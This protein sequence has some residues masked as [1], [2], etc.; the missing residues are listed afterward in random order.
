[1]S[2]SAPTSALGAARL[3]LRLRVRRLLN[4]VTSSFQRLRR[5]PITGKRT[6]TPAKSKLGWFVGSLVA[7]SMVFSLTNLARQAMANIKE[8]L[9]VLDASGLSRN[10]GMR[11]QTARDCF[12]VTEHEFGV[13][14]GVGDGGVAREQPKCAVLRGTGCAADELVNGCGERQR[15]FLD[16]L[17]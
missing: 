14:T 10:F 5:Q 12:G 15:L 17:V 6:A 8:R 7:L 4:Q 16:M 11:L 9:P 3:I 1:M 2:S 13:Q